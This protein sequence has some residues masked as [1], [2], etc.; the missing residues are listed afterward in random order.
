MPLSEPAPR[1]K[2]NQRQITCEG[3]QRDD[4]MWDVEVHLVD[5]RTRST[6]NQWRGE[7]PAGSPIHDM[8][9]R[10]TVDETLTIRAVEAVMDGAPFPMRCPEVPPNYQRLVGLSVGKGFVKE[11]QARIGR[12]DNCTHLA[13]MMQIAATGTMQTIYAARSTTEDMAARLKIF[14]S[15]SDR[16]PL[17]NA[18]H[19]YA[20][21]SPVTERFWPAYYVPKNAPKK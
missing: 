19:S 12:T 16:P 8:W 7:V 6:S 1:K 5:T 14:S 3:Y 17:L 18:C 15:G 4:G 20:D 2:L 13:T 9:L 11:A 21:D 10:W